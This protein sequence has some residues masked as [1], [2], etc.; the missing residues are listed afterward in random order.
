MPHPF[1]LGSAV[2]HDSLAPS[3]APSSTPPPPS[4]LVSSSA[5][6]E[7][8]NIAAAVFGQIL[9]RFVLFL[10]VNINFIMTL[11]FNIHKYL[12]KHLPL[13]FSHGFNFSH[14]RARF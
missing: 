7:P 10:Y 8:S 2:I 11:N 9:E 13:D 6:V 12:E 5:M 1:L 3:Q 14:C 4:D